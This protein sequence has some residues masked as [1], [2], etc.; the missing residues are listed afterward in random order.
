MHIAFLTPEFPHP[1]TL[2]SGGLGTSIKNLAEA[3]VKNGEQVSIFVYGQQSDEIVHQN[4][5]TIHLIKQRNYS[6]MTWY[7][8][9][10]FIQDYIHTYIVAEKIDIIE[11]PDWTGFSAVMNFRVPL[12][13]RFHGSDAYFCHLEQRKQKFKNFIFE[14][15]AISKADAFIA[16]TAFA[17][18]LSKQLFSIKKRPIQVIPYGLELGNFINPNPESYEEGLIL[19]IGTVIR[20]KGVFELPEILKIAVR[21]FPDCRL[22]LIGNDAADVNTKTKSTWQLIQHQFQNVKVS[23]LGKIPY[24]DVQDYI[25]KAHVCIFPTFAET[26]GMVTIESMAMNKPVVNSN[27]GWANELIVDGESGFLV[28]PKNHEEFAERILRILSDKDLS[29]QMGNNARKRVESNF[30]IDKLAHQNLDF[31]KTVISGQ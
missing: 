6:F 13:I 21:Q 5:I 19:Y 10:K 16:P 2:N 26:L 11:A 31:Y 30:D 3:L 1:K 9:N 29:R 7:L 25:K 28:H 22:L 27:I 20:K 23:F 18:N 15:W 24:H 8:Y 4:G 17:G 12:V 14:K